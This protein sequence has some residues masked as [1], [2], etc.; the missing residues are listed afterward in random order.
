MVVPVSGA[1]VRGVWS[2][3]VSGSAT[4]TTGSSGVANLNS[5]STRSRGTYTFTVTGVTLAGYSYQASQNTE[6]SDSIA[7]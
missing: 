5:P 3:V 7:R 2:G 4:A 1:S 6:T